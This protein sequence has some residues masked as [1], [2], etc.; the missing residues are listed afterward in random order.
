[1]GAAGELT[2]SSAAGWRARSIL[3]QGGW[4]SSVLSDAVRDGEA[5][6]W[7]AAFNT[8]RNKLED[9]EVLRRWEAADAR[10]LVA[11]FKTGQL[12]TVAHIVSLRDFCGLDMRHVAEIASTQRA[13]RSVMWLEAQAASI[14]S[15]PRVGQSQQYNRL[16]TIADYLEFT[17]SVVTQHCGHPED[18][19]AIA[20]MAR[21]IR[22]H[23]PRGSG[24]YGDDD[25]SANSPSLELIERFMAA[26][27][28][29][30]PE[31]PFHGSALR[32]RNAIIF[33][34]L[35]WTGM[36]RGELLSLRLDQLDLGEEPQVWVRRN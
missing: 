6:K 19:M 31:N 32:L 10:D 22:D 17:A 25:P 30:S 13:M 29:D 16:S 2:S 36:R 15:R 4:R 5:A 28:V 20:K 1:M 18:A 9:I 21:R 34:L 12:L 35:R 23:R 27:A 24:G 11:E 14:A 26:M 33:G 8:I 3:A 7:R